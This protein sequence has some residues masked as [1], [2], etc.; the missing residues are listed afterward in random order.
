MERLLSPI[1]QVSL[2]SSTASQL[3]KQT[4]EEEEEDVGMIDFQE[5]WLEIAFML[6][7]NCEP[8][9]PKVFKELMLEDKWVE[10]K[11]RRSCEQQLK[12]ASNMKNLTSRHAEAWLSLAST[13]KR[14][15]ELK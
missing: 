5:P 15:Q 2:A 4:P 8:P 14:H 12:Q 13:F 9:W 1:C 11:L 6:R 3:T 7:A 10:E